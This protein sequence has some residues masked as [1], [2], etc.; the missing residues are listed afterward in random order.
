M[1]AMGERE[2]RGADCV[3]RCWLVA[4][5]W[6]GGKSGSLASTGRGREGLVLLFVALALLLLFVALGRGIGGNAAVAL[7]GA[8]SCEVAGSFWLGCAEKG[9]ARDLWV[10]LVLICIDMGLP[11]AADP[12]LALAPKCSSMGE[13][14]SCSWTMPTE[15]FQA[16]AGSSWLFTMRAS[17]SDCTVS[18]G[19][20]KS[21]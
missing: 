19:V 15:G 11:L 4:A 5:L 6:L 8:G 9:T 10:K 17:L 2:R 1:G 7:C 20:R 14:V 21:G 13:E 12:A 16:L 3:L 18:W